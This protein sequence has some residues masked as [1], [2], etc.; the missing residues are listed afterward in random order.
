M[1]IDAWVS[2]LDFRILAQDSF[3][4]SPFNEEDMFVHYHQIRISDVPSVIIR[5]RDTPP[6]GSYFIMES[7]LA[8]RNLVVV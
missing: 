4:L 7:L 8:V 5:R 1:G 3:Q 2:L 6:R